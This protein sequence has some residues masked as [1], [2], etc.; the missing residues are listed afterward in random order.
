MELL[1][2]WKIVRK[3]W[4]LMGL[5][6]LLFGVAGIFYAQ[7]Q[8]PI[9]STTTTMIINPAAPS[10]LLP[11]TDNYSV[12]SL[13][14]TYTEFMRT[15]TFAQLV[16]DQMGNVVP[17][18]V[19]LNSLSLRYVEGTQ[20]F[21]ITA[22]Y[23]DPMLTQLM[24]NTVADTLIAEN[25]ARQRSQQQQAQ[26][27]MNGQ[28]QNEIAR[29][30]ELQAVLQQEAQYYSDRMSA[31]ENEINA[32]TATPRSEERDQRLLELRNEL[33]SSRSARI[34]VLA[35]LAQTQTTLATYANTST[36]PIDTAVIIDRAPLPTVPQ[37]GQRRQ[38][39]ILGFL[40]GL[41]AGGGLAWLLEYINYTV[42]SPEELDNYYGIPTQ[43]AIGLSASYSQR[44]EGSGTLVT[45]HEPR[46]P[47]AEAFRALRT[48]VRMANAVKPVRR[49]LVTSAGPSEGKTFIATNLAISLA[50]EG[51]RVIL[52]DA[53][54]RRPQVHKA[55]SLSNEP[56]LTNWAVDANVVIEQV[57][58][59]TEVANLMVLTCGII[60]PNP[61][62]L[63]GSE[64]MTE[65]IRAMD[66]RADIVVYDSPPAA[67]VTDAVI[68]ATQMDGVLQVVR[69][70]A[71]RIDLIQRCKTLLE[72]VDVHILGPVLNGVRASDLGYYANYY[73]YGSYYQADSGKADA[74]Q[75]RGWFGRKRHQPKH[76]ASTQTAPTKRPAATNGAAHGESSEPLRTGGDEVL[77]PHKPTNPFQRRSTGV[78]VTEE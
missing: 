63:L 33:I 69:A 1:Q 64:R 75:A 13:A 32:V 49:L 65:L 26:N 38:L 19:I 40:A 45:L 68:L 12:Q 77:R 34:D 70:G 20:I 62:E 41:M 42:R 6:T 21:R 61:A 18:G 14:N 39:I 44:S 76:A 28:A 31:L 53:D 43:G 7:R 48:S 11:Y 3:W 72:R 8:I 56:G 4:W 58:R 2:Y 71:T 17:P 10:A 66:E 50:Q 15:N 59:P 29:L 5:S 57:L 23:S 55:F 67:T 37:P 9:Y 73:Y 22:T 51:K 24:A 16:A 25:I 36:T 52:V 35:S 30:T 74:P 47:I 54:L 60:P 78:G 27:Q 46:S